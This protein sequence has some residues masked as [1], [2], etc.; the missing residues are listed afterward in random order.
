MELQ[1]EIDQAGMYHLA[2]WI[3]GDALDLG[4]E[5]ERGREAWLEGGES[6]YGAIFT[7]IQ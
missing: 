2:E 6:P 7:K 3:G 1:E 5:I 4:N